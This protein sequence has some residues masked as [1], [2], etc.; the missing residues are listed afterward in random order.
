MLNMSIGTR[1][2]SFGPYGLHGG[3]SIN[4]VYTKSHALY[5]CGYE[6]YGTTPYRAAYPMAMI[7]KD[8]II[9]RQK[10]W[11]QKFIEKCFIN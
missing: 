3:P 2:N 5:G 6:D 10:S 1:N 11:L 9:A 4:N 7:T 8:P